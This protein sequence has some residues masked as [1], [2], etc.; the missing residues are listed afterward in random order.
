MTPNCKS[1]QQKTLVNEGWVL[2]CE[3]MSITRNALR[4]RSMY[5][6]RGIDN[7]ETVFNVSMQ[8]EPTYFTPVNELL[9]YK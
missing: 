1:Q 8:C 9:H 3:H 5:V 7:D 6:L 2:M 4:R